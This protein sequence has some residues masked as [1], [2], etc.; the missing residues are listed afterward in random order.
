[1]GFVAALT[2]LILFEVLGTVFFAVTVAYVLHP[3]RERLAARGAPPRIASGMAALTGLL[4]VVLLIVP[5]LLVLYRRRAA[6]LAL[7]RNLPA[8]VT[9]DLGVGVYV[10]DVAAA[11]A[12]LRGTLTGVAVDLA[13]AAPVLG[14]KL[15][16]FAFVVYGLLLRPTAMAEVVDDLVPPT[17]HDIV[18]AL[19]E[20]VRDTLYAIYVLQAATAFA[21]FLAALAVFG[22][23]GYQSAVALAV[24]AGILQFIPV[25]GPSILVALLGIH[26]FAFGDPS[27]ALTVLVAGLVLIG[28]LPDALVRP[29]LAQWTTKLPA[30]VYFV[31]FTGGVLSL[32]FVGFVAGPLIVAVLVESVELAAAEF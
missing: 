8:D 21:T 7:L 26:D 15:F 4:G 10:V 31:G 22:L 19:H 29:R 11:T 14:L 6:L 28:F 12:A 18:F 16:L 20:R 25:V 23:L 32:G 9:V 30:T 13:R 24:I 2:T 1:M 17:Y 27:R 5:L 3:L